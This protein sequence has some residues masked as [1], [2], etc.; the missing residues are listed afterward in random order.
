MH[1]NLYLIVCCAHILA[2]V[3]MIGTVY[4]FSLHILS[5]MTPSTGRKYELAQPSK[6]TG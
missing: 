6:S 3:T 4:A 5:V 1:K 2:I